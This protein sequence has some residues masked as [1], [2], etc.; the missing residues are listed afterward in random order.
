MKARIVIVILLGALLSFDAAAQRKISGTVTDNTRQGL[1]GA[2]VIVKEIPGLGAV[3]DS[4][5]RYFLTLPKNKE[6][7]FTEV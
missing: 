4:E 2:T 7:N 6:Y 3:T 5:G 1:P